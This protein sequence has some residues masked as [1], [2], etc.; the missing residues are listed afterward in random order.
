MFHILLTVV[1]LLLFSLFRNLVRFVMMS[2][3]KVKVKDNSHAGF[4]FLSTRLNKK[5]SYILTKNEADLY[6]CFDSIHPRVT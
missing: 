1:L 3:K 2:T 4:G 6:L 5:S